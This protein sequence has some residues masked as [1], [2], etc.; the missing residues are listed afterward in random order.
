VINLVYPELHFSS[1]GLDRLSETERLDPISHLGL[2]ARTQ[3]VLTWRKAE[4]LGQLVD[5]LKS[6]RGIGIVRN[7]GRKSHE[8]LVHAVLALSEAV[9]SEGAVDWRKYGNLARKEFVGMR[10]QEAARAVGLH[11]KPEPKSKHH[12]WPRPFGKIPEEVANRPLQTLP[13]SNRAFQG[14]K[15]MGATTIG[16][17]TRICATDLLRLRNVG[18]NTMNEIHRTILMAVAPLTEDSIVRDDPA[19]ASPQFPLVP[20]RINGLPDQLYTDFFSELPS[21]IK[22]IEGR[23]E[24][25]ILKSR[26]F[27]P[28]SKAKTLNSIGKIF[29]VTR[30]RIR[31]KENDLMRKINAALFECRYTYIKDTKNRNSITRFGKVKF[32]IQPRFQNICKNLLEEMQDQLPPFIKKNEWTARLAK[33]LGVSPDLIDDKMTFW[34]SALKFKEASVKLKKGLANEVIIF[35]S[36]IPSHEA[37]KICKAVSEFNNIILSSPFGITEN[38]VN[39]QIKNKLKTK[40]CSNICF[41]DLQKLSSLSIKKDKDL[42]SPLY[43]KPFRISQSNLEKLVTLV[44][45][46]NNCHIKRKTLLF[47]IQEKYP[48]IKNISKA[49]IDNVIAKSSYILPIGKTGYCKFLSP[50]Q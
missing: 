10:V 23:L 8:E 40:A 35:K 33:R 41:F 27:R 3:N 2:T 43:A 22:K 49:S 26:L 12:A 16:D 36:S 17:A 48:S 47:K 46:E 39:K 1:A 5:V 21:I 18:R 38:E 50:K 25:E 11:H 30:E 13:F 34:L 9:D 42:Y 6:E 29:G 20:A 32:K 15:N 19:F 14:L 44:L 7:F 4:T 37:N 24:A 31:Q 45:K 28:L